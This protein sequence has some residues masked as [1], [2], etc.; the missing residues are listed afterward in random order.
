MGRWV[1]QRGSASIMIYRNY[2]KEFE[3]RFGKRASQLC[4]GSGGSLSRL[5]LLCII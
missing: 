3:H 2:G 1:F 5:N 4:E